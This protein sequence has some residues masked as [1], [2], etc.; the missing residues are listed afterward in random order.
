MESTNRSKLF[1]LLL[2]WIPMLV[3]IIGGK[4][5]FTYVLLLGCYSAYLAFIMLKSKKYRSLIVCV[6]SVL[7][8][9]RIAFVPHEHVSIPMYLEE[10]GVKTPNIHSHYFW[11]LDHIH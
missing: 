8:V 5:A 3:L 4:L 6:V 10:N 1:L 2:A 11:E 9:G 7:V